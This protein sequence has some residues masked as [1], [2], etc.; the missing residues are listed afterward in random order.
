MPELSSPHLS[1]PRKVKLSVLA[2]AVAV[3]LWSAFAGQTAALDR[4]RASRTSVAMLASPPPLD[5][6]QDDQDQ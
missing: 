4:S 6:V 3:V 5:S 2:A 1:N